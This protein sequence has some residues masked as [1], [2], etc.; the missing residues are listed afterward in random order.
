MKFAF[1]ARGEGAAAPVAF[2]AG[3]SRCRAA[4]STPGSDAAAVDARGRG[5][6]ARRRRSRAM[7]T[8]SRGRYGSPRV[9]DELEAHGVAVSRK[10]VARLMREN[11]PRRRAGSAASGHD[12]LEARRCPSRRTCSTASSRSTA[13]NVAWVTDITYIWTREGWLYLAAILDLFSR[14][15][16]GWAMSERIDRAARRSRPCA[17][18]LGR[19][20]A[21][22]RPPP[23]LRPRLA[24]RERRLPRR[25]RRSAAS[26]AA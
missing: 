5:R 15:V 16:V 25:A 4:A 14:R 10:R 12:G 11:G 1:I 6:A 20:R 13:P 7:H 3:A 18:A 19:T 2:C 8:A 9:H 26:S 21:R 23:S 22:R 24:V 17:M